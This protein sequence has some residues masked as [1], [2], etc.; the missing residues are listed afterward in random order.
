MKRAL[1]IA[2]ALLIALTA[3]TSDADTPSGSAGGTG[4]PSMSQEP[5]SATDDAPA[6]E[7]TLPPGAAAGDSPQPAGGPV[8]LTEAV[9]YDGGMQVE[10]VRAVAGTVSETGVG[11]EA[12]DGSIAI[13]EVQVSNTG[14]EPLDV[15]QISMSA[16]YGEDAEMAEWVFDGEQ[17]IEGFFEGTV[18]PGE[19][20]TIVAAFAVPEDQLSNVTLDVSPNDPDVARAV[21]TGAVSS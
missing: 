4:A 2:T 1:P 16:S 17:D 21:F 11:A 5:P 13:F 10:I 6:A 12:T 9:E 15:S 8:A 14:T 20:R 18:P 3:C 19:A 7:S